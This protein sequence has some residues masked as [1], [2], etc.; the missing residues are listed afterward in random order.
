MKKAEQKLQDLKR[1]YI[2]EVMTIEELNEL[3]IA[4]IRLCTPP[5]ENIRS[6][7]DD[8][9]TYKNFL[10]EGCIVISDYPVSDDVCRGIWA[11]FEVL[12]DY[13]K[14]ADWDDLTDVQV[15]IIAFEI[16]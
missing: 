16:Y 3:S 12:D 9:Y 1:R 4:E 8:G 15:K 13:D 2:G 10:E 11:E 5:T 7:W 14:E 6:Q